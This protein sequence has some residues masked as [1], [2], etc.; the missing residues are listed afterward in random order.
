MQRIPQALRSVCLGGV[1]SAQS[2]QGRTDGE[3]IAPLSLSG[4]IFSLGYRLRRHL[5]AAWPLSRWLG[6]LILVGA[7][8][9]LP[10][11]PVSAALGGIWLLYVS[12]LAWASWRAF[13]RFEAA[14]LED[15]LGAAINPV[16]PVRAEEMVPVRA[17]G[18]FSVEGKIQTYM[19]LEADFQTVETREHVVL[20]RV[21]PSR[22]LLLGRW[23]EYELGWWY[24][25]IKP[26]TIAALRVGYLHFGLHPRPAI[27]V[28]SAPDEETQETAYLTAADLQ[29][30]R[31]IWSDLVQDAPSDAVPVPSVSE[32]G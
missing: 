15:V 17:S 6:L 32:S 22:F 28:V 18:L 24:V 8:V 30:L 21:H 3:D 13:V 26:T 10:R 12:L 1:P 4:V 25:F 11:W 7:V 5:W 29:T 9:V 16:S 2:R 23:P 27:Q 19:D 20:A 31:R 14:P